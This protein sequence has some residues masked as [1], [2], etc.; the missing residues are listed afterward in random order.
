M[1]KE[2]LDTICQEK[3]EG[4]NVDFKRDQYHFR[5]SPD[6]IAHR[7]KD[8]TAELIKDIMAFANAKSDKPSYIVI[9]V[10]EGGPDSHT[11][12]GIDAD[13]YVDDAELQ[14]RVKNKTNAPLQFSCSRIA[15]TPTEGKVVQVIEIA[16]NP[17]GIQY[18]L[19]AKIEHVNPNVIY[20]RRGS[21]TVMLTPAEII[22]EAEERWNVLKTPKV[23]IDW[24]SPNL[25]G[26]DVLMAFK[27]TKV[28]KPPKPQKAHS[29]Y[30]PF[31]KL[32]EQITASFSPFDKL[33]KPLDVSLLR[34][35]PSDEE[36]VESVK[37]LMSKIHI[38][39]HVSLEGKYQQA[40][41]NT[42]LIPEVRGEGVS[43]IKNY[44]FGDVALPS[45]HSNYLQQDTFRSRNR[46]KSISDRTI[47]PGLV[48]SADVFMEA[49]E[50]SETDIVLFVSSD[51]ADMQELTSKVKVE[52]VPIEL[53]HSSFMTIANTL[54]SVEDYDMWLKFLR[55]NAKSILVRNAEDW[56]YFIT[57]FACDT[58]GYSDN[59]QE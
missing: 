12:V 39:V 24:E 4:L 17:T 27:L 35:G 57:K 11:I 42:H 3:D 34:V 51:N 53:Y 38:S 56:D 1:T 40:A 52:V 31:S 54:R 58:F 28:V 21:S 9:G 8:G 46:F 30:D 48:A 10:N 16:P 37:Y 13:K 20:R 6:D 59:I 15:D 43:I 7:V 5:R 55:E 18:Y 44:D 23:D 25:Q 45:K 33:V 50:A 29:P 36:C 47:Q 41:H 49:N 32:S 26:D 22:A 19:K 14:D 2:E